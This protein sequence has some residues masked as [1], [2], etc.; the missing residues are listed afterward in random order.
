MIGRDQ[1]EQVVEIAARRDPVPACQP[2][3]DPPHY[4]NRCK[5]LG[6]DTTNSLQ[7]KVGH[8][9]YVPARSRSGYD[10]SGAGRPD[11]C[12][13]IRRHSKLER[14]CGRCC[15]WPSRVLT[16]QSVRLPVRPQDD[17]SYSPSFDRLRERHA[18]TAAHALGSRG[19]CTLPDRC[20]CGKTC[21][22]ATAVLRDSFDSSRASERGDRR[23]VCSSR[24]LRDTRSI[25]VRPLRREL[26][27]KT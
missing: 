20:L 6:Y 10:P 27:A 8:F 2:S 5:I 15:R 13:T 3:P 11:R 24:L 18:R 4:G 7:W 14:R 21:S 26:H 17:R 12:D 16:T 22:F 9:A 25:R 19:T 1:S 23:R